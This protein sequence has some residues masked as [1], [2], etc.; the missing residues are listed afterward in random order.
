MNE[1]RFYKYL[2]EYSI[3]VVNKDGELSRLYCPFI[4]I[5]KDRKQFLVEQVIGDEGGCMF[6]RIKGKYD[7]FYLY[8][9]LG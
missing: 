5:T 1:Y 9:I 4:V 8:R 6:Y 3:L 2:D 7:P